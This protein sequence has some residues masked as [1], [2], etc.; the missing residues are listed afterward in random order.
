MNLNKPYIV[1]ALDRLA[2]LY[3]PQT[4]DLAALASAWEVAL[5]GATPE[6]I[7]A[8]VEAYIRSDARFFP[9]PGQIR[10][11]GIAGTARVV[12]AK[13]AAEDPDA[14]CPICDAVPGPIPGSARWNTLH[15]HE[16]HLRAG[17]GYAGPRTGPARDGRMAHFGTESDT[18]Y[19]EA[20]V[21]AV[22]T[23]QDTRRT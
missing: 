1:E 5:R 3:K 23:A 14:P 15:D 11:L 21:S 6:Q 22:V 12:A 16:K 8:G 20:S 19:L 4:S 7:R 18:P 10:T 13:E 17:I 2:V 9:K